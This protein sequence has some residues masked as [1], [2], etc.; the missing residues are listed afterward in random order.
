MFS[1]KIRR[2]KICVTFVELCQYNTAI[3]GY[4][5]IFKLLKLLNAMNLLKVAENLKALTKDQY[6]VGSEQFA[7]RRAI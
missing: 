6:F 7:Y 5:F 1:L 3:L 2:S 4:C